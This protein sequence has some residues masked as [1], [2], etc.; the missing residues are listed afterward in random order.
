MGESDEV[1]EEGGGH[2][3]GGEGGERWSA[4]LH[5]PHLTSGR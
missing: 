2:A 4:V 5:D 1:I 3:G